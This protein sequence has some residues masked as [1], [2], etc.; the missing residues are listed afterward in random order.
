MA[1]FSKKSA[2]EKKTSTDVA[3]TSATARVV[4]NQSVILRPVLT[5]KASRM[6]AQHQFTFLVAQDATRIG[7]ARAVH[8]LY[9]V[10]PVNVNIIR[11]DGKWVKF[12]RSVGRR[13]AWKKAIVTVKSGETLSVAQGM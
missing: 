4:R 12:G 9:G 8:S 5:E 1:L 6:N 7:V 10:R 3:V 13:V 2:S 11:G